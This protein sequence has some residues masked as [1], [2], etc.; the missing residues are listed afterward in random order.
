MPT[1][2]VSAELVE[3]LLRPPYIIG[4]RYLKAWRRAY[5][6]RRAALEEV[7]VVV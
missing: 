1:E 2:D 4:R 3:P 5:K 7:R 6:A